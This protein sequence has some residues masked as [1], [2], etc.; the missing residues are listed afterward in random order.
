MER[1]I[2][3]R[4][5]SMQTVWEAL[6]EWEGVFGGLSASIR[7]GNA[8]YGGTSINYIDLESLLFSGRFHNGWLR[9]NV[10]L[11]I[12]AAHRPPNEDGVNVIPFYS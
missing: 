2:N 1:A 8:Y 10:I 4:R 6:K 7:T 5:G 3:E 12:I 11:A 9:G